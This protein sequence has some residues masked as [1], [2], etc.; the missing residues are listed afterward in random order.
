VTCNELY[1][2]GCSK[3]VTRHNFF[4]ILVTFMSLCLIAEKVVIIKFL[5]DTIIQ[6]MI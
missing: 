5:I 2:I 1:E 6:N 4:V 3:P